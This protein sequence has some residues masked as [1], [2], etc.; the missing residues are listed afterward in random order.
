M[1]KKFIFLLSF[2]FAEEAKSSA[3]P[4]ADGQNIVVTYDADLSKLKFV[5]TVGENKYF[6]V[7]FGSNMIDTDMILFTASGEGSVQDMYST[8]YEAPPPDTV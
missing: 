8:G 4:T 1:L 6:S 3:F 5:A 2:T 7:G